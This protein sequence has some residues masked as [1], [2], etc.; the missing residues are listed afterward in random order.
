MKALLTPPKLRPPLLTL[1]WQW[2]INPFTP[3]MMMLQTSAMYFQSRGLA[4]FRS[5]NATYFSM[6]STPT[7]NWWTVVQM[8]ALLVQICVSSTNPIATLTFK[9]L[10]TMK[11]LVLMWLLLQPSSTPLKEKS[12][13]Y[14]MN[15]PTLARAHP[16]IH[17]VNLNGL[18]PMLMKNL[19]KLVVPNLSLLWMDILSLSSSRMVW[20]MPPPLENPQIRTW[21]HIHMS[22]SPLLM[23]ET[24][25]SWT[26]I[27]HT[28][29]DWTPVKSL[30]HL[31]CL[32]PMEIAMSASLP[33]S[34]SS[35]MH[36]QKIVGHTQKSPLFSQPMSIRVHPKSL[37]GTI[38]A[39]FLH[40]HPH[41]ASRTLS[42]SPPGM[43]LLHTPRITSKSTLSLTILF[44]TS[45][46]AVKLL[47]Q[48]PSSLTLLLLMM[49]Q[50]WPNSSV[51]VILLSVMPM[52]SKQPN[53]SSTLSLI[54]SETG[55]P[56]IPSSVMEA[57]MK[58]PSESLIS[59]VPYS[60]KIIS[61]NLITNT[62]I[63]LKIIL[64]LP[65]VTPTL[66]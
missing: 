60:S 62:K 6:P 34:T 59:S 33:T 8:E 2:S 57:N 30:T 44:S 5:V 55:E 32:M 23:N 4:R 48:T 51:A 37:T 46:D 63:R 28:L 58:S 7:N 29:M 15:M 24:P 16:F 11:L 25:Q 14:S 13:A 43:G 40:G 64:D 26:M 53:N 12:L 17:Q 3:L 27:L 61:L 65:S 22:S 50:P 39:H 18:R 47:Q 21:T 52:A 42:M 31:L 66:S 36:L 19:S 35:W 1:Y 20:P 54:T 45:P 38:Y 41:P 10:I 49:V 56:W 9:A